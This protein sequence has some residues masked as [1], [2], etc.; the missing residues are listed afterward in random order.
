MLRTAKS[1]LATRA[2]LAAA[3]PDVCAWLILKSERQTP[4]AD[5]RGY[6]LV[7]AT[8]LF[9]SA[10]VRSPFKRVSVDVASALPFLATK[11]WPY[12]DR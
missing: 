2:A 10:S 1:V 12:Y 4:R 8:S 3:S 11:L 5:G 6:P 7:V 9:V